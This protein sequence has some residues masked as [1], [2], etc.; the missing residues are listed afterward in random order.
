[1]IK[2]NPLVMVPGPTPVARSIQQ[3]MGRETISFNDPGLVAEFNALVAD[4]VS[5]WRCDGIA[6]VVAGSG[7][8]AMEMGITNVTAKGDRVLLCSNG[9]FGERF[10]DICSR[11]G[12][13]IEV[14]RPPK[15]GLSVTVDE[16]DKKL[17]GSKFDVL[18]IT[19]IETSTGVEFP[20]RELTRMMRS[21]HPE[22]LIVVDGVA[23]MGG[24]EA[25]M[26]WGIDVML[27]CSQK[28][29]GISPGLALLWASERAIA[30]RRSMPPLAESY[31]DFEKWIPVMKDTMKYWGTPP[32]N[33]IWALIEAMRIIKE[34]GLENRFKRHRAYAAAIRKTISAMGFK[35]GAEE[36][37][38]SPTV[39]VG[40][41]P[42]ACGLD[43]AAFRN[44]VYDEGAHI[45]GCLGDFA[46]KGFRIG[47]MG[48]IDEHTLV[49]LIASIERACIKC[50]YK[51][52]PGVGLAVMQKAL[53]EL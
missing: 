8:M 15:W 21:K 5:I 7:T 50:G 25:Y 32:V 40:L 3:A 1:M 48:N 42:E 49:S 16:V 43:D 27:S 51:I 44:A 2:R 6:F 24:V 12:F 20:L 35:S 46:G 26:D 39:T 11:K 19:H 29:F 28:C 18:V 14:L 36:N 31:V 37:V 9:H 17:S 33:M 38:A 34:E 22:T 10:I 52:E 41:Y 45:A 47:H 13:D 53:L 23:S 30:R 4:L